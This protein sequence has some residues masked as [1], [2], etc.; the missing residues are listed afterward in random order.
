[1]HACSVT[2]RLQSIIYLVA[3]SDTDCVI[4]R[5]KIV[6]DVLGHPIYL[7]LRQTLLAAY[8]Y[9]CTRYLPFPQPWHGV[10]ESSDW[11]SKFMGMRQCVN[12]VELFEVPWRR[13][14]SVT[15]LIVWNITSGLSWPKVNNPHNGAYTVISELNVAHCIV[16]TNTRTSRANCLSYFH[17]RTLVLTNIV[18]ALGA[19]CL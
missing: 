11:A 16:R 10:V 6:C 18:P 3:T 2:Y 5:R 8:Q 15:D 17:P 9:I 4:G 14:S 1:M 13:Q 19:V 7:I 12:K